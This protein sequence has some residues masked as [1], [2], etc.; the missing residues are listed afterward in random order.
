HGFRKGKSIW[1]AVEG[2]KPMCRMPYV[3][4]FDLDAFFNRVPVGVLAAGMRLK[5]GLKVM[6]A[7]D[8]I[9]GF[10]YP[11]DMEKF[12]EN[13]YSAGIVFSDKKSKGTEIPVTREVPTNDEGRRIVNFL[14]L[15]IDLS[16]HQEKSEIMNCLPYGQSHR[17][18]FSLNADS[19][20]AYRASGI[21]RDK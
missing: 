5:P 3:M 10:Y 12:R 11:E 15:T 13:D 21:I 2:L 8:G 19:Y 18:E 17:P 9:A 1:S 14:G 6:Y 16:S 20:S 4:E 7:D